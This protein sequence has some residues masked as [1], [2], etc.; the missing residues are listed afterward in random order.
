MSTQATIENRGQQPK[1]TIAQAISNYKAK[2]ANQSHCLND[3]VGAVIEKGETIKLEN[4]CYPDAL[5]YTETMLFHTHKSINIVTGRGCGGFYAALLGHLTNALQ[6]VQNA[7]GSARMIVTASDYPEWLVALAHE[8]TGIF[9]LARLKAKERLQH[10]IV[11]DSKIVR[12]EQLHDEL[13]PESPA[14]AIKA[15]VVFNEPKMGGELEA[16]FEEFWKQSEV[17][18]LDPAKKPNAPSW[19]IQRMDALR[20]QP[21]P[22]S[23]Q[24]VMQMSA[25]AE[26]RQRLSDKA[27]V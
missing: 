15:E 13:G 4:D 25:A 20:H 26:I 8:F 14:D 21:P 10:F 9:T 7:K 19:L 16:R 23:E 22:T 1:M 11:C 17:I 2:A 3:V 5:D 27:L 18:Q 6:R 12:L 24:V